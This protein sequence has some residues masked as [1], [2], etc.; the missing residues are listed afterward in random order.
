[1]SKEKQRKFSL[2]PK[3]HALIPRKIG[4]R[5]GQFSYKKFS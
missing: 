3:P 5:L 4:P 1:M 2:K